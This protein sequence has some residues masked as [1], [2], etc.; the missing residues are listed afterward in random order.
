[1]NRSL[2]SFLAAAAILANGP[3]QAGE[4]TFS[5]AF[6]D[7][8]D[9][10]AAFPG[11]CAGANALP[12][13]ATTDF[14]VSESGD[15]AFA[16]AGE[17]AATDVLAA[18]YAGGFSAGNPEAGRQGLV[19]GGGVV[20]LSAGEDYVL[21]VQRQCVDPPSS[22]DAWAVTVSGP[23]EV[24][25]ADVL[26]APAWSFGA[27]DA[28]APQ[29]DFGVGA[30]RYRELGPLRVGSSGLYTLTDT[31][32]YTGL[33]AEVRLYQGAFNPGDPDANRV[34]TIDDAGL[35]WLRAGQDYRVVVTGFSPGDIGAFRLALLPP[36]VMAINEG[37]SGAWFELA[38]SGQGIVLEVFPDLRQVFL[39]WFTF[40]VEP[41]FD[42]D[43]AVLGDA[44][45]RWVTAQGA[46]EDG[47]SEVELSVINTTG[48]L[49]D[50]AAPGQG[51]EPDYGTLTLTFQDCATATLDYV[52]PAGQVT[53]SIPL[54][55]V[56]DNV[57]TCG[58]R[59]PGPGPI[60]E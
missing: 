25:G 50:Q 45:Q 21:V 52:L 49:F 37:L 40:D 44:S 38:T 32:V 30:E 4:V 28:G 46:Y 24:T 47:D 12:W 51:S 35:A 41:P 19:D 18:V 60:T 11:A 39:A 33:D 16:D 57:L 58:A 54:G 20:A 36:G 42:P 1:M 56:P 13:Q 59:L 34:A 14:R 10:V 29:A 31:G 6:S 48:G 3:L 23:G 5:G 22:R 17:L 27:L 26:A 53:G 8:D 7:E 55:R 2:S 9:T 43:A 15:Y